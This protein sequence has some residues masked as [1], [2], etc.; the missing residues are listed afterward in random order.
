M[1]VCPAWGSSWGLTAFDAGSVS[2]LRKPK[3]RIETP[4]KKTKLDLKSPPVMRKASDKYAFR[5]ME[6]FHTCREV[7]K[8]CGSRNDFITMTVNS[9]RERC[10]RAMMFKQSARH[11]QG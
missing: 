6:S 3:V 2:D 8:H 10:Y 5:I 11:F 9:F 1:K 7:G 4:A